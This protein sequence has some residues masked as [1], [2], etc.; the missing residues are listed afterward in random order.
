VKPEAHRD[1][2]GDRLA[3]GACA[4]PGPGRTLGAAGTTQ[5]GRMLVGL[6]VAC[7]ARVRGRCLDAICLHREPVLMALAPDSMAWMAGQ[8][9][10]DRRGERW[11]QVITP[12]PCLAHG[13]ADGGPGRERGVKLA[14]AARG[15]QGQTPAPVASPARPMGLDVLHPQRELER[16]IQRQWKHAERQREAARQAEAKVARSKRRGRER[17]GGAGAA[18]RA[19]RTAEALCA[20]AVRAQAAVRQME[21]ALSWFDARGR[22]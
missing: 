5:A 11:S 8:R 22:L 10:P 15:A 19:G 12:W 21:A 18:G 4:Q 14:Q 3:P 1:L 20:Q 16:V 9:G 17:R 6:D 7:Q 13:V 2:V